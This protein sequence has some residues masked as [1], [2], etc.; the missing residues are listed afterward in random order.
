MSNTPGNKV[1]TREI[2]L[3]ILLEVL[4]K[5]EYSHLVIK[6]TLDKYGYLEKADRSFIN[7]LSQGVI[8]RK[9]ELDYILNQ[10]SKTKVE[11]MKPMIRTILRMGVYQLLYME[12]IPDNAACN[13]SVKL[14]NAHK[15]TS[16][17]GFVNG[18]LRNIAR[19]KDKIVYPDSKKDVMKY[20]SVVYSMPE[21]IVK[22]WIGYYGEKQTERIL[23]GLIEPRPVTIRMNVPEAEIP[24]LVEEIKGDGVDI[25][26]SS[27]L[28]YAYKIENYDRIE[29]LPG[30]YEGKFMIQDL[31]SMM[32]T[33]MAGIKP[34][35]KIIDVCGAP[36]GKALHAAYLTGEMGSVDVRDLSDYKVN[37]IEENIDRS[38]FQNIKAKVW[39]ATVRDSESVEKADV[40]IADLPCSGLGVIGR[41]GEIKYRMSETDMKE[42]ASLQRKILST[43][44]GYVKPGGTLMYSTCTLTE[45]ENECNTAWFLENFQFEEVERRTIFPGKNEV[46]GDETDGFYMVRFKKKA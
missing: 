13:E 37:L 20:F 9:L 43:V 18:V 15:F 3:Q 5:G 26:R 2:V 34:G 21:W 12:K 30:Y 28:A 41:K 29:M 17:K 7:R 44:Q 23:K 25:S 14:A 11:K 46:T 6:N 10:F 16:L 45:E 40:V 36:G 1:N 32:I 35:D 24:S 8:E 4:E 38:G 31:G 33:H 22:K 19:N 39:D 27:E 42:I